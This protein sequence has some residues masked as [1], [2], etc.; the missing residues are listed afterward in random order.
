MGILARK[1]SVIFGRPKKTP[2]TTTRRAQ[3]SLLVVFV[4]S[5]WFIPGNPAINAS[6]FLILQVKLL[7]ESESRPKP[8]ARPPFLH[9]EQRLI[10][11]TQNLKL[12]A[13]LGWFLFFV[14]VGNPLATAATLRTVAFSGTLAP[15]TPEGVLFSSFGR[16]ALN[17]AGQTAF[18]G[19]L[20]GTE[21]DRAFD[22]GIWSEGGGSGL[23]LVAREGNEAPGTPEG[24]HFRSLTTRLALLNNAGPDDVLGI[25]HRYRGG[26]R[27]Q[28]WYLVG[29]GRRRIGTGRTFWKCGPRYTERRQLFRS[30]EASPQQCRPDGVP[31]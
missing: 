13:A 9:P 2:T 8:I 7:L 15:G 25:P 5:L 22:S 12:A 3:R 11:K 16:P 26:W 20:T 17:N 18:V 31:G 21:V 1:S 27:E 29:G 23:A 28:H 30:G 24:V 14:F 10:M 6:V 19:S 4:V